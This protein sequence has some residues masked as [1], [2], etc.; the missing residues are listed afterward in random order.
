VEL[1]EIVGY[2]LEQAALYRRE[3]G[4]PDAE[5][6]SEA[7]GRLTAAGES[8]V[9]REDLPAAENLLGRALALLPPGDPV[10]DRALH[11][12]ISTLMWSSTFERVSELL[13]ALESSADPVMRMNGRVARAQHRLHF[14]PTY[15]VE[16]MRQVAEEARQ[17]FT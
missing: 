11:A 14:D 5:T 12:L 10:R 3:L 2:H 8:A 7:A 17:L 13:T 4:R 16:E 9:A 1:D 6:D 15:G